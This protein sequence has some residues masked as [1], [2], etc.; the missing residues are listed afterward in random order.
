MGRLAADRWLDGQIAHSL[1]VEKSAMSETGDAMGQSCSIV[2]SPSGCAAGC[3]SDGYASS[4]TSRLPSPA[5]TLHSLPEL[6]I[7]PAPRWSISVRRTF[8]ECSSPEI[9]AMKRA[10]SVPALSPP[11]DEL[12][13]EELEE[14]EETWCGEVWPD[15]PRS[16]AETWEEAP[17]ELSF[18]SY[19]DG[20]CHDAS[21]LTKSSKRL[22]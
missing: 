5:S 15:T 22:P 13:P 12:E 6:P 14:V 18:Q 4:T 3:A 21:A 11:A 7:T 8:L 16:I 10:L 20:S 19:G 2:A 9:P 1:M 17:Q